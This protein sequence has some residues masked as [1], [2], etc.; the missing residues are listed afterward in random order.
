MT[1]P[2]FSLLIVGTGALATLFAARLRAAGVEMTLLGSWPE[3]VEALRRHGARLWVEGEAEARAFSVRVATRP[4]EVGQVRFALV[5]V[6]AWQTAR[7]A[8][9]L[10]ACLAAEGVALTLQNGLGNVET[11]AGALGRE[12]VAV[13]VTT[14]GATLVAPGVVRPGGEGV[15]HLGEHPRLEPVVRW[16]QRAGFSVEVSPDVQGLIW[17][18]LAVN[19]AINPLTT[20][21]EVPNGALVANA[22][23]RLFL[24]RA[25]WEVQAV[26]GAL[27][28]RLPFPDAADA[29]EEVARRTARNL[30]SMLQDLRRGAPTEIDAISGAV[31]RFGRQVGVSTPVNQ[32][33]WEMVKEKVERRRQAAPSAHKKNG[34]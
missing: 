19:A 4:E 2:S 30:S 14:T 23:A 1:S 20:L 28:V 24:R 31:V 10:Q 29:A 25:A 34:A 16:L 8:R 33:L 26:A 11:L 22:A 7:A 18:K 3:G 9:H 12:R 13:G 17:G 32:A 5:L 6:K 21:L 27:G 15:I